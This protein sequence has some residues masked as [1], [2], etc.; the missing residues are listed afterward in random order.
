VEKPQPQQVVKRRTARMRPAR[1][2]RQGTNRFVHQRRLTTPLAVA[3]A[4]V[5][6]KEMELMAMAM[7]MTM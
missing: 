3:V 5:D 7:T 2:R 4:V 1:E 6:G